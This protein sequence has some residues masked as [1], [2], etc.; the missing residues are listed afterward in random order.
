M[1][2]DWL[3]AI[4][5]WQPTSSTPPRLYFGLADVDALRARTQ[6]LPA[7]WAGIRGVATAALGE[8]PELREN[9]VYTMRHWLAVA[10]AQALVGLIEARSDLQERAWELTQVAFE[11]DDW[12][13]EP[14]KPLRV[15]LFYAALCAELGQLYDWLYPVL[16]SSQREKLSGELVSR[17]APFEAITARKAD[18]W[19]TH[20]WVIRNMNWKSV[21]HGEI[22]VAVLAVQ[23]RYETA[24]VVLRAALRGTLEVL[25]DPQTTGDDGAYA[26][27]LSY[28]GYAMSRT[29]WLGRL[30]KR[31]TAG[32][33]DLFDHPYLQQTGDW[34]LHMWTPDGGSFA[35]ED[36][37]PERL[38]HPTV[39]AALA[40]AYKR[41]DY[42]WIA[43]LAV[44]TTIH[45]SNETLLQF[46]F[47]DPNLPSQR[48]V[49]PTTQ[50]F[51]TLET[52]AMRSGWSDDDTFLGFH[53]G[54]TVVPHAHLDIGTFALIGRGERLVDDAGTWPYD[55]AAGFFNSSGPRWHYEANATVGHNTV[56]VDGQGQTYEEGCE[57][58]IIATEFGDKADV[59]VCDATDAYSGRLA[60]FVRYVAYLKPDTVLILDDLAAND[61]SDFSW[62][63]HAAGDVDLEGTAW[64]IDREDA[65]LA[66]TIL[67][68][69]ELGDRGG[70]VVGLSDRTSHYEDYNHI[71]VTPT[72]R[73]IAFETL[74]P[75]KRWL[76]P[77]V[78]HVRDG[79]VSAPPQVDL[80][81]TGERITLKIGAAGAT[82]RVEIDLDDRTI[83]AT[84]SEDEATA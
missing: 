35:H 54:A 40:N 49:L 28:W 5:E 56:L 14:H 17:I 10:S 42:Q 7:L 30:L 53:A 38:P 44:G 8:D 20:H 72:N 41:R 58:R 62:L 80:E 76:V 33:I 84:M 70:F 71:Y 68:F 60:R 26:E 3:D 73:Y 6:A 75:V 39:M 57:G 78:L 63:L 59:L 36:C 22:G 31:A 48:P 82:W 55:H 11:H 46:L 47:T 27:G 65:S 23:D 51:P 18:D 74:H 45:T 69:D 19:E 13:I 21:V 50:Y 12:V 64:S 4:E 34:A 66:V 25:D 83:S 37:P 79:G 43:E 67:G 1:L 61:A 77:A 9:Q 2:Q 15:D 32:A 52:V 16:T 81:R 24:Q 29:V